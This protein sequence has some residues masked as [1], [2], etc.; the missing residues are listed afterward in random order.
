MKKVIALMLFLALIWGFIKYWNN[1]IIEN[2]APF[3]C[4]LVQVKKG[5]ISIVATGRGKLGAK[6]LEYVNSRRSGRVKKIFV[7]E[8][9]PV[10]KNQRLVQ[11]EP[12]PHFTLELK[13]ALLKFHQARLTKK[14]YKKELVR[15]RNLFKEGLVTLQSVEL[16]EK[17]VADVENEINMTLQ[18]LK[19]FEK[20]TGQKIIDSWDWKT[21]APFHIYV[22]AP[23]EG[24]I[25]AINKLIGDPVYPTSFERENYIVL[26]G[27]LSEYS[28]SYYANEMDR[29]LIQAGQTAEL[30]FDI[31]S[32]KKFP[33]TVKKI[34]YFA[35]QLGT[36]PER[37]IASSSFF[38]VKLVLNDIDP[39]LKIGMSGQINIIVKEKKDILIAPI[40]SIV[41]EEKGAIALAVDNNMMQKRRVKTGITNKHYIEIISGIAAGEEI[42]RWPLP[43]F[44]QLIINELEK[45]RSWIEK[46]IR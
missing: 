10:K 40:E 16:A 42:C 26:I 14:R 21:P 39:E 4:E 43:I 34:S 5:S 18:L 3:S 23:F 37:A 35:T 36:N 44:E 13:G 38:E 41:Q 25:M 19:N 17:A 11:I 1:S 2:K 27:D 31:F 33:A 29:N 28:V 32:E 22:A 12:E 30:I 7:K 8:G 45:N 9:D 20:E 24:T 6:R 46:L 15:Q